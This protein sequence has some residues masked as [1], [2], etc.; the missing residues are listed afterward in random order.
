M[1][2][3]SIPAPVLVDIGPD[4]SDKNASV[5]LFF[6]ST[7]PREIT[8]IESD[9]ANTGLSASMD[10]NVSSTLK[11]REGGAGHNAAESSGHSTAA[12]SI[13]TTSSISEVVKHPRNT[14]VST[15]LFA[16]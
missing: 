2:N 5:E 16:R 8:G 9:L 12:S 10:Y 6:D 15:V 14:I 13:T 4:R 7:G 1:K 11:G 3:A